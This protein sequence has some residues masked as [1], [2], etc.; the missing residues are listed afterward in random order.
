MAA[1]LSEIL[2]HS[3]AH[4][5]RYDTRFMQDAA[6]DDVSLMPHYIEAALS[7]YFRG[8]D[9]MMSDGSRAAS[10]YSHTEPAAWPV[11]HSASRHA[12]ALLA[13]NARRIEGS[14]YPA[15]ASLPPGFHERCY[16]MNA[17]II[18]LAELSS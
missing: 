13:L 18:L 4:A 6:D 17:S 10:F 12:A 2:T 14:Y 8:G 9:Y 1:A 15:F 5:A 11:H 7:R 3:H 16:L